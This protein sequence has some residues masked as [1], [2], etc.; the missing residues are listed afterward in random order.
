MPLLNAA[1]AALD[2]YLLTVLLHH[3]SHNYSEELLEAAPTPVPG[4][5]RRAERFMIDNAG[6]PITVSDVADHLGVSLRTLQA[7]FRQWRSSTPSTFLRRTR[8]QLAREELRAAAPET[9]VTTIALRYGFSHLGRFAALYRSAFGEPP[10][11]TLYRGRA[12]FAVP[13]LSS[14][15]Q[16][17]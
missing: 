17:R 4:V 14:P 10:S 9:D 1:K 5:V 15:R 2:E 6:Q 3:H 13:A 11:A 7:G 16:R 8:L 12:I